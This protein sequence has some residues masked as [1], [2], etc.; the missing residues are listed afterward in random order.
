MF[1]FFSAVLPS[2]TKSDTDT[3]ML[4]DHKKDDLKFENVAPELTV[5]TT[6][7]AVRRYK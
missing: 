7:N 1:M 3:T 2:G 5:K 4:L 6:L